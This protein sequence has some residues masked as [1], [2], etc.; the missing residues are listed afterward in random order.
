MARGRQWSKKRKRKEARAR[1]PARHLI[2]GRPAAGAGIACQARG[3]NVDV[4]V[5]TVQQFRQPTACY[6]CR[7]YGG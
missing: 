3:A 4:S 2:I 5:C 1:Q 7:H 6:G